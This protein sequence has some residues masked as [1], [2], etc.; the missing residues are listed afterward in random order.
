[1]QWSGTDYWLNEVTKHELLSKALD[2]RRN[3]LGV[4][5]PF[6]TEKEM[7]K[8]KSKQTKQTKRYSVLIS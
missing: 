8:T 3:Q 1:M 5:I 7:F 6:Q 2:I 4:R